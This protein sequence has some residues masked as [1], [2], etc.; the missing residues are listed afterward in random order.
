MEDRQT[1]DH[2]MVV[3]LRMEA[4]QMVDL[5]QMEA[6]RIE[7]HLQMDVLH[8][9]VEDHPR[10]ELLQIVVDHQMEFR[11]ADRKSFLEVV[12]KSYHHHQDH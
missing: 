1:E 3:L 8:R 7:G 4:L 11:V 5:P 9:K 2:Q 10:K 6:H 12:G